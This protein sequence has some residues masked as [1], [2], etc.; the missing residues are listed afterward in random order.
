MEA[1]VV[2]SLFCWQL[3]YTAA[4]SNLIC[5]PTDAMTRLMG[6]STPVQLWCDSLSKFPTIRHHAGW[7]GLQDRCFWFRGCL[8]VFCRRLNE[9]AFMI[10]EVEQMVARLR[11]REHTSSTRIILSS[12]Q[13]VSVEV[14]RF[15]VCH[16]PVL[17]LR[18][19][20][21]RLTAGVLLLMHLLSLV[22]T[23]SKAP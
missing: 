2:R 10:H 13:M 1:T 18:D 15:E 9:P 14:D 4:P 22:S 6:H 16:S 12:W 7:K 20:K 3:I 11:K 21:G 5:P 17:E 19:G 8:I 23:I